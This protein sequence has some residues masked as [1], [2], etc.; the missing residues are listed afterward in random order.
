MPRPMTPRGHNLLKEEL[1]K[2]K[3]QRPENARALETARA[4]G[5]LSENA[6]YD[7][8]KNK[9]GLTE[10]RIRDVESALSQAEIIDPAM[11]SDPQKV[12]FGASVKIRDAQSEEERTVSIYGTEESDVNRG[13]I[14]YESPLGRAL[15]GKE[16]GELVTVRLPAGAREYEVL[17]IFVDYAWC[18]KQELSSET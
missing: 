15:I 3:A 17:E 12:L 1:R 14:S 16:V 13:W 6:D 7:A 10:A 2:L 9:A 18:G 11:I 5:D 8:A 4:H